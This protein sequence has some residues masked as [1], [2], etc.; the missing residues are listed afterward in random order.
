MTSV[1]IGLA[2]MQVRL[3]DG[4]FH[5]YEMTAPPPPHV[6][7][8]G[9]ANDRGERWVETYM[10]TGRRHCGLPVMQFFGRRRE[11]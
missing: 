8:L 7:S 1:T 3:Q 5:D 4:T 9:V 2:S 11:D 10:H 6:L